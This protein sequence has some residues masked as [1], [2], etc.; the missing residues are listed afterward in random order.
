MILFR[1]DYQ[2]KGR[3]EALAIGRY[4]GALKQTRDPGTL[5]YSMSLSLREARRCWIAPSVAYRRRVPKWRGA[6]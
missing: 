4:D 5:E 3:R 1:Y 6:P 2:L